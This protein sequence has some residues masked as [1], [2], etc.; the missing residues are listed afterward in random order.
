MIQEPKKVPFESL[1]PVELIRRNP[2]YQFGNRPDYFQRRGTDLE[3]VDARLLALEKK[4]F[5]GKS[6]L[7]VGCHSGIVTLQIAKHFG[8]RYAKGIDVDYT[9]IN[10]AVSNWTR[11]EKLVAIAKETARD[12]AD[13][14][15]KLD[16]LSKM[17]K[18]IKMMDAGLEGL[19]GK[20]AQASQSQ[21][22]T[23]KD[24]PH[25]V[26]FEIANVLDLDEKREKS[27]YDTV[28]C[29]SLTKWIHLNYGDEG[30]KK[31]FRKFKTALAKG[32]LLILEV[33]KF[34]SYAKK[35]K[36]Y[37]RFKEIFPTIALQPE[38]FESYLVKELG[39]KKLATH[40]TLQKDEFKRDIEV[41]ELAR[42]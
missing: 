25:N 19:L 37:P 40:A 28:V 12:N 23:E 2:K 21:M 27:K 6:V 39:F 22:D 8:S 7:D 15:Q 9:L 32:G 14:I 1:P 5:E 16:V 17:P 34:K 30:V 10:E 42:N 31:M 3:G 4:Y 41:Y 18:N 13:V 38:D 33:Q 11:E 26:S 35:V 20:R 24:Y 29:F 36:E